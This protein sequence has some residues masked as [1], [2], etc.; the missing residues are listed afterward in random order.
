[1]INHNLI[2]FSYSSVIGLTITITYNYTYAIAEWAQRLVSESKRGKGHFFRVIGRIGNE[3]KKISWYSIERIDDCLHRVIR[4]HQ[5][6]RSSSGIV[7]VATAP[8]GDTQD[9]L[10]GLGTP[11]L[12]RNNNVNLSPSSLVSSLSRQHQLWFP[13]PS[14]ATIC[15]IHKKSWQLEREIEPIDRRRARNGQ[16]APPPVPSSIMRPVGRGEPLGTIFVRSAKHNIITW[17]HGLLTL[18]LRPYISLPHTSLLFLL[19]LFHSLVCPSVNFR[20]LS[21][22]V[23]WKHKS[24]ARGTTISSKQAIKRTAIFL[25]LWAFTFAMFYLSTIRIFFLRIYKF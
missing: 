20:M 10:G 3:W 18:V 22:F 7:Y 8:A 25:D 19:F 21:G 23:H 1:M 2:F 16:R 4:R 5:T 12:C 24:Y 17:T 6:S 13:S 9:N 11:R 15:R 14:S